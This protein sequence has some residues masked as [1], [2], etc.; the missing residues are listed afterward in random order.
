MQENGLKIW[1]IEKF[2]VKSCWIHFETPVNCK[3]ISLIG[4]L[5]SNAM[6]PFKGWLCHPLYGRRYFLMNNL[7][8]CS[9]Q[10][11]YFKLI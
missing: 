8:L 3:E 10:K 7:T 5:T 2:E 4:D 9:K 1:R 6:S 11:I